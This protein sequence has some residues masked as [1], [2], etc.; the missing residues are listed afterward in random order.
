VFYFDL[1]FRVITMLVVGG[2][3]SVSG[4][5]IGTVVVL[6]VAEG[7]RR[8]EDVTLLY[9]LSGMLL[10]AFFIVIIIF[11]PEG[12]MGQREISFGRL[13]ARL[14]SPRGGGGAGGTAAEVP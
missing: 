4:S 5:V 9:G 6:A 3:G 10:A 14:R 2:M 1:T 12:I 11:R 7:L 8:V 13:P